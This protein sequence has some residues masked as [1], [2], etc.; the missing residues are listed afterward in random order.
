MAMANAALLLFAIYVRVRTP[1]P[2]P[3]E[4][5]ATKLL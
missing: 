1:G 4:I 3:A 2:M 5:K